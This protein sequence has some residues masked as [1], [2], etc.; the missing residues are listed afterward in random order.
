[1]S[2][3]LLDVAVVEQEMV[4]IWVRSSTVLGT[5]NDDSTQKEAPG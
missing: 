1:M 4:S 3:T 5:S 2:R